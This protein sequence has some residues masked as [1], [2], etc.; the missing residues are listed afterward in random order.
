M[1]FSMAVANVVLNTKTYAYS[2]DQQG[3]ITWLEK[4]GGVPTGYQKLTGSIKDSANADVPVRIQWVL[5]KPTVAASDSTCSC[6]GEVLRTEL[7]RIQIELDPTGSLAERTDLALCL[8]DLAAN[9]QFQAMIT[10]LTRPG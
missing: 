1:E 6:T 4:S 9:A 10:D 2:S 3:I 8:K 5:T 7:G